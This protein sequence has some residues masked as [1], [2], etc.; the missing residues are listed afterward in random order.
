MVVTSGN[1]N[2]ASDLFALTVFSELA[3][4]TDV[5]ARL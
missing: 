1:R 3:F 4:A 2:M 5:Y